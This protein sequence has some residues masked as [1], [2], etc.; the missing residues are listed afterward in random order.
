MSQPLSPEAICEAGFSNLTE[1]VRA[2][3]RYVVARHFTELDRVTAPALRDVDGLSSVQ[4]TYCET[5]SFPWK[6]T[7]DL[8]PLVHK[9]AAPR[10]RRAAEPKKTAEELIQ[11]FRED[12]VR[13]RDQIDEDQ[14]GLAEIAAASLLL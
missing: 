10:L 8:H 7:I 6:V 14:R 11:A 13:L 5:E 3:V 9:W 1:I 4:F 12:L 2:V